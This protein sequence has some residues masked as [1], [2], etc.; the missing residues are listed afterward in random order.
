[1]QTDDEDE[2][3]EGLNKGGEKE[4]SNWEIDN[5]YLAATK[6]PCKGND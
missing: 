5:P 1:M 3:Q 2:N 4:S 6:L